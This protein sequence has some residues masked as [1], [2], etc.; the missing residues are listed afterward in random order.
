MPAGIIDANPEKRHHDV[1]HSHGETKD[2]ARLAELGYSQGKVFGFTLHKAAGL[3]S[4]IAAVDL[5]LL[6][7][8]ETNLWLLPFISKQT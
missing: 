6:L 8:L 7:A 4:L 3:I 1:E 2:A 5:F